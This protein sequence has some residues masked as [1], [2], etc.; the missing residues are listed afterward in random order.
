MS[1]TAL[2]VILNLAGM[3]PGYASF[4]WVADALGRRPAFVLYTVTAAA[5]VPLY[6]ATRSPWSVLVVGTAVAFFGTG[7][8]SGSSIIGS[9]LFPTRVRALA[10]SFTYSGA[11]MIS[12][13]APFV[14][15]Y[16]GQRY[17]TAQSRQ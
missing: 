8:F 9:E 15:G 4:G 10:L 2:L 13:I 3:S 11:R 1:T 16:V 17:A 12:S 6:A 5:L 7:F 14:I